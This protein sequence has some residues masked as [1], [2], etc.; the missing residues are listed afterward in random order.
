MDWAGL[1]KALSLL[2]AEKE[3]VVGFRR[4]EPVPSFGKPRRNISAV[5]L[6]ELPDSQSSRFPNS[7]SKDGL[8]VNSRMDYQVISELPIREFHYIDLGITSQITGIDY[9]SPLTP[10]GELSEGSEQQNK[11]DSDQ[12][13]ANPSHSIYNRSSQSY[14]D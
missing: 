13:Q 12:R 6:G 10:S 7:Q 5:Q 2:D 8:L 4:R 9:S 14:F 1:L 3:K 11:S